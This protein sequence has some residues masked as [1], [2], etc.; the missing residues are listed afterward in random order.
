[1]MD[2]TDV[3]E[4]VPE[5]EAEVEADEEQDTS[6]DEPIESEDENEKPSEISESE[7]EDEETV[8]VGFEGD[9]GEK[10]AK[11]YRFKDLR[12]RLKHATRKYR[13]TR[14]ELEQLKQQQE[15]VKQQPKVADIGPQP[16]IDQC[17]WDQE[18]FQR[19]NN[20]WIAK[21][22]Q[23]E[24]KLKEIE[25][26]RIESEMAW[27]NKLTAYQEKKAAL[28]VPDFDLA[29]ASVQELF[30]PIQQ[31]ILIDGTEDPALFIYALGRNP[32]RAERSW[33]ASKIT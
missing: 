27:K 23:N 9:E 6:S 32:K 12:K 20:A 18:E 11:S 16:T 28:K 8:V 15:T 24:L 25:Q 29:E 21:K 19:R 13:D 17:D 3:I 30:S 5:V 31:G 4:D 26:K 33:L 14:Q 7:E 1:M 10:P 22:V 2:D